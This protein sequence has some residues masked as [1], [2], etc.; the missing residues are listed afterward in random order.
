[1]ETTLK[2]KPHVSGFCF[3]FNVEIQILHFKLQT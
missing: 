1:M 2:Q 3:I